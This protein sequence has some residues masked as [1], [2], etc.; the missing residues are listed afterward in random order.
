M[1]SCTPFHPLNP[2]PREGGIKVRCK[3]K[4]NDKYEFA[5]RRGQR[6]ANNWVYFVWVKVTGVNTSPL[7]AVT[8]TV[9]V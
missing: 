5:A 4:Q 1:L 6:A 7:G 9:T 3:I 8:S 2:P